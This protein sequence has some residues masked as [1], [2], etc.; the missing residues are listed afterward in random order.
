MKISSYI[1]LTAIISAFGT[2]AASSQQPT[3]DTSGLFGNSVMSIKLHGDYPGAN[4]VIAIGSPAS[5]QRSSVDCLQL[6]NPQRLFRGVLDSRGQ[7]SVTANLPSSAWPGIRFAMQGVV[8]NPHGMYQSTERIFLVGEPTAIP[9]WTDATAS[10]PSIATLTKSANVSAV[11]FDK[12]GDLDLC[13]SDFGSLFTGGSIILF[14][15]DGLGNF[16]DQS[17]VMFAGTN[18]EPVL[19]TAWC[20]YDLDGDLDFVAGGG[21]DDNYAIDYPTYLYRNDGGIFVLDTL[22]NSTLTTASDFA[23]GDV[24]S[25]GYP[26]LLISAGGHSLQAGTTESMALFIN[27]AGVL[28]V[29]SAF[30]LAL[31]NNTLEQ[32]TGVNLGDIDLDGDLDIFAT[33]SDSLDGANNYILIN[34]GT[35]FFSDESALRMPVINGGFGD[36]TTGGVLVDVNSD[37]YLDIVCGNSHFSILPDSSGD[38]LINMGATNPGYFTNNNSQFPVASNEHMKIASNVTVG[39]IDLDGDIDIIM[40]SAEFFGSSF[41]FIGHPLLF[42]NQGGLQNGSEGDFI[43]DAAFWVNGPFATYTSR[44]GVLF[45]ADAD[46]DL[47]YYSPNYGGIVDPTNTTDYFLINNL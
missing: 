14:E 22:L 33:R 29:D 41:P 45:D 19:N 47:D 38:L 34:D 15:N 6:V 24:N 4:A 27:N 11:D 13:V 36:K 16:T 12:D 26:D 20:D 1:A 43:E 35:G 32:T 5:I 42:V 3:L 23:W 28:T 21:V 46:G 9:L 37:G 17:A 18:V 8:Q 2:S 25:D 44:Q 7:F 31:F 40:Q 39:D 30:E 10:L